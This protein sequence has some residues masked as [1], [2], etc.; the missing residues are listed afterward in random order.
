[1]PTALRRCIYIVYTLYLR[2]IY[3]YGSCI[4]MV[5]ILSKIQQQQ[6]PLSYSQCIYSYRLVVF[7]SFFLSPAHCLGVVVNPPPYSPSKMPYKAS[8]LPCKRF[9]GVGWYPPI[10]SCNV[11][12]SRSRRLILYCL[13]DSG[14]HRGRGGDPDAT[15]VSLSK[16]QQL[17][18]V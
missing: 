2:C 7:D 8:H 13:I 12:R 1:M 9:Y 14:L 3:I 15:S 11:T 10:H 17:S 6:K 16:I 4:Y 18:L 5:H